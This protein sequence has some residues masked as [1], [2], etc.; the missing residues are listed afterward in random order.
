M[1]RTTEIYKP[2]VGVVSPV[3]MRLAQTI[4]PGGNKPK[5]EM[6]VSVSV[7]VDEHGRV[8]TAS[9]TKGVG[10]RRR[11]RGPAVETAKRSEFRPA[12]KNGVAGR[13]WTEMRIVFETE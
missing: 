3:L 7:L 9:A 12:M 10:F 11:Y 1:G 8:L 13:M 6:V 2:G 4:Y 5:T